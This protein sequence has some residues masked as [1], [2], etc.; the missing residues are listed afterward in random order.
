VSRRVLVLAVLLA[1]GSLAAPR[2]QGENA[3]SLRPVFR[4][5]VSLV[6]LDA[7]VTDRKGRQVTDLSPDEFQV[8]QDGRRQPITAAV[9]IQLDDHFVPTP[10]PEDD[11]ATTSGEIVRPRDA[12]RTIAIVIDDLRM[13]FVSVAHTRSA[14]KKLVTTS[15]RNDDFVGMLTTSGEPGTSAPFSYDR[16]D[17]SMAI[18]RLRFSMFGLRAASILEPVS[19]IG[20]DPLSSYREASFAVGAIARVE[21]TIDALREKPGRKAVVLVSEGFTIFAPGNDN[22]GIEYAMHRL[23]D[24]ANRAGVV[25]YAVDPRGLVVTGL[26]AADNT[27]GMSP[28]SVGRLASQRADALRDTQDGLRYIAGETGGFAVVDDNDLA[29]GFRRVLDDQQGYY[30][31]GYQP[32]P[33]TF[34]ADANGRFRNVKVRVTRKGVKVRTR[35]G[36]YG[37]RTE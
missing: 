30:L 9:Y 35:A 16:A 29:A 20:D 37:V 32:E 25:I 31:V 2:A 14:L 36:F 26:T 15:L 18:G 34:D 22:V 4:L 24:R 27:S 23:V 12:R 11:G 19:G 6:Q 17:L 8:Y 10:Y 5:S 13:G 21:A 28:H 3:D 7:V 33:G 1:C